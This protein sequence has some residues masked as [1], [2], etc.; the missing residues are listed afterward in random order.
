MTTVT[1]QPDLMERVEQIAADQSISSDE[2]LEV[3]VRAY[4]RQVERDRIKVEA[5]A[6]HKMH[7]MLAEQHL[8]QYVA[9]F[10]GQLV[11][12]DSDFQSLHT[13]IR[14]RYARE[15]VLLRRVETRPERELVF[16]SPR[17]EQPAP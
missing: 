4:I 15:P 17:L 14:Q 16:R 8:G 7:A 9:I 1:L 11:D 13:R 5:D 3:A 12:Y 2:L 10:Q 6:F